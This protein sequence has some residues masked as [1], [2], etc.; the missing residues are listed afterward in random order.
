MQCGQGV[1]GIFRCDSSLRTYRVSPRVFHRRF[2]IIQTLLLFQVI[3]Y[4]LLSRF[5]LCQNV[6]GQ[7]YT[8]SP[9]TL[10]KSFNGVNMFLVLCTHYVTKY[11]EEKNPQWSFEQWAKILTDPRDAGK[12]ETDQKAYAG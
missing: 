6:Y 3:I 11:L 8:K 4:C 2:S 1:K 7:I 5:A 10:N 9:Y 12:I